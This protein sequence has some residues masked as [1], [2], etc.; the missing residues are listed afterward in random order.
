M[1]TN[2]TTKT[3]TDVMLSDQ[4]AS[5]LSGLKALLKSHNDKEHYHAFRI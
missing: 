4:E 2:K 5:F 1:G 3:T